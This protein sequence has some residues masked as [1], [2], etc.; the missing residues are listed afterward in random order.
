MKRIQSFDNFLNESQKFEP[1]EELVLLVGKMEEDRRKVEVIHY[2][3]WGKERRE[4]AYGYFSGV[5]TG[6]TKT[7][8]QKFRRVEFVQADKD[9][10]KR[11]G[12]EWVVVRNL[13]N[14]NR[15]LSSHGDSRPGTL[16]FVNSEYLVYPSELKGELLRLWKEDE[17]LGE[18]D[19]LMY[20]AQL[21]ALAEKCKGEIYI[22]MEAYKNLGYE[23]DKEQEWAGLK[24]YV[25]RMDLPG[26]DGATI[27]FYSKESGD[28]F[29]EDMKNALSKNE[30]YQP[31]W[32]R[33][34]DWK[35][36]RQT[37]YTGFGYELYS[38]RD[39]EQRISSRTVPNMV[40][41]WGCEDLVSSKMGEAQELLV[42]LR[43]RHNASKVG[44]LD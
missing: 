11:H 12:G 6:L 40:K 25:Y 18:E 27:G 44:L 7:R 8:T 37:R 5:G 26:D 32:G 21:L 36:V 3:K 22:D 24:T 9:L 19:R 43:K 42:K 35:D 4:K 16:Y 33:V 34:Y 13:E 2:H 1:G 38:D 15:E 14:G 17:S 10:S 23:P 29:M 39:E 20:L 41:E 30:F 28:A 31:G